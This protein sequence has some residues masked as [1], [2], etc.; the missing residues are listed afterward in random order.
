MFRNALSASVATLALFLP[1]VTTAA[2]SDVVSSHANFEAITY[3]NDTGIITGYNDGTYKPDSTI[4]RAEFT[5]IIMEA[6]SEKNDNS[7]C[8]PDVKQ[9]W[10]A[11]YVCNAKD[12]QIIMGYPNGTFQP[13]NNI[14]FVEAAKII[15]LAFHLDTANQNGEWY[16]SFVKALEEKKAIPVTINGFDKPIT[17]GEMAEIIYR[18][19]ANKTDKPSQT[20]TN[21]GSSNKKC[22]T[23]TCTQSLFSLSDDMVKFGNDYRKSFRLFVNDSHEESLFI[24]GNRYSD[25]RLFING[26]YVGQYD[27]FAMS[28]DEKSHDIP[29]VVYGSGDTFF[30]S[31]KWNNFILSNSVKEE[32][33]NMSNFKNIHKDYPE[34]IKNKAKQ[35]LSMLEQDTVSMEE[36]FSILYFGSRRGWSDLPKIKTIQV[37]N[38]TQV[39]DRNAIIMA[40]FDYYTGVY[41]LSV[42][43]NTVVDLI[44][45]YF[46]SDD[47]HQPVA[48]SINGDVA[49]G[50]KQPL[51]LIDN[52]LIEEGKSIWFNGKPLNDRYNYMVSTPRFSQDGQLL[53]Y[54]INAKEQNGKV[55]YTC[56][57]WVGK[58]K[59]PFSCNSELFFAGLRDSPKIS[60]DGKT[61]VYKE[62][63]AKESEESFASYTSRLVINGKPQAIH[64]SIGDPKFTKKGLAV[65][66]SDDAGP[67]VEWDGKKVSPTGVLWSEGFLMSRLDEVYND[68]ENQDDNNITVSPSGEHIAF[69]IYDAS[70]KWNL[71]KDAQQITSSSDYIANVLFHPLDEHL[72][73]TTVSVEKEKREPDFRLGEF[74]GFSPPLKNLT[75]YSVIDNGKTLSEH[76]KVLW[77][78][79]SPHGEHLW[80]IA[81]DGN[82]MKVFKDGKPLGESFDAIV[83]K[84]YFENDQLTLGILKGNEI[85]ILSVR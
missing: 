72:A 49:F 42:Q 30:G 5:K 46:L 18:L 65:V 79:F 40:S 51:Q 24:I 60:P 38:V 26:K 22:L 25:Y 32:I 61:V 44:D 28:A 45:T 73:Y 67:Y 50:T 8:F 7:N 77:M 75:K 10:F 19:Q 14:S 37:Y 83:M 70:K 23:T 84:P 64:Q 9:E 13:A 15:S 69:T 3:L 48:V 12:K 11:K 71:Y 62:L 34:E 43:N 57:A 17:R 82:T 4:N 52:K 53:Y 74:V 29:L 81:Q 36:L 68:S 59:Y 66:V 2:F 56:D 54:G 85:S 31:N 63:V 21:I 35:V 78:Q 6:I 16:T 55:T 20:F 58:K 80:Y 76:E 39:D 33:A 27:R 47:S 1:S 41:A